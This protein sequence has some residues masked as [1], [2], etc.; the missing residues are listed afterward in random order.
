MKVRQ[1]SFPRKR[2]SSK[3]KKVDTRFREYDSASSVMPVKKGIQKKEEN[4]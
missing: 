2:E 1:V 4:G 3:K